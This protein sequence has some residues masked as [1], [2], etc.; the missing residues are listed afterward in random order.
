MSV[1][2]HRKQSF[3]DNI[4]SSDIMIVRRYAA[5]G[6]YVKKGR[7]HIAPYC[8]IGWRWSRRYKT[9]ISHQAR[10]Q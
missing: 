3:E 9:L 6:L 10:N 7:S 8:N 1:E 2:R 4:S 5:S